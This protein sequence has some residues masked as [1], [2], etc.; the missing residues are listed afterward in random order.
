MAVSY[1]LVDDAV[2]GAPAIN[3][4]NDTTQR[5][6]LGTTLRGTDAT[7]GEAEFIYVKFTGT[8]AAGDF[9]LVDRF[10]KT[11]VA[12]PTSTTKGNYG[13][14]MAAQA[15][16]TTNCYG[17]VMIRGVHDGANVVTGQTAG[18]LLTGTATAGRASSGTANYVLDGA[19]LKNTAASN[20]GTVEIY[21]PVCSGR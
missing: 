7:Y 9:V 6:V 18:T 8:V 12:S 20:V 15:G 5:I 4:T 2:V 19:L 1:S 11:A 17:W 3:T 16:A 10:A 13:L 21:W 14:A